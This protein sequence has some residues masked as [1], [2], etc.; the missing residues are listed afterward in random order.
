MSSAT[1]ASPV[2]RRQDESLWIFAITLLASIGLHFFAFKTLQN[3][4]RHTLA[5]TPIAV[6]IIQVE[7][8]R[9][10]PPPPEEEKPRPPPPKARP[11]PVKV[12]E[13]KPQPKEP[14]PPN[15]EAKEPPQ[16]PPPLVVGV[17]MS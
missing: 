15:E 14:P 7:P 4:N 10:P 6:E 13:V 2:P 8:P 1:L 12:A 17:S 9:P 3:P 11:P 5:N 16:E